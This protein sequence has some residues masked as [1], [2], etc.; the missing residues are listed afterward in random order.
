MTEQELAPQTL[1]VH[2]EYQEEQLEMMR[3]RR[4]ALEAAYNN[5]DEVDSWE[6]YNRRDF[7][8]GMIRIAQSAY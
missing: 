3:L 6:E 5:L 1:P 8:D 2:V 7:I 4:K